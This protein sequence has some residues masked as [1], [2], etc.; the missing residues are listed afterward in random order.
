MGTAAN[1][2]NLGDFNGRYRI[3]G[4]VAFVSGGSRSL[5]SATFG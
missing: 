2:T 3:T 1:E 5:L 4:E